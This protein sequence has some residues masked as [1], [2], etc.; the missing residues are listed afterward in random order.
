MSSILAV[1]FL[2]YIFMSELCSCPVKRNKQ[3]KQRDRRQKR[4]LGESLETNNSDHPQLIPL[5]C[6]CR[7]RHSQFS[8]SLCESYRNI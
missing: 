1:I 2:Y 7:L 8:E 5:N 3:I 4:G 6:D